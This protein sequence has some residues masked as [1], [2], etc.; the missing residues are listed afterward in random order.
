M[1]FSIKDF[2]IK[3]EQIRR[4]LVI[5]SRLLKKYLTENFIFY[6]SNIWFFILREKSE[7][8]L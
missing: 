5:W 4:N 2:F 8:F 7:K 1:K 3:C 6:A